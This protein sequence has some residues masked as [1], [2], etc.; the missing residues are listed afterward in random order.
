M[1]LQVGFLPESG[2]NVSRRNMKPQCECRDPGCPCCQGRC[3]QRAV[4]VLVRI[5]MEDQTGTAMCRQCAEDALDS[6]L[7]VE[8]RRLLRPRK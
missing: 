2:S 1:P 4:T 7:F 5:D 3:Q 8:N 6:G